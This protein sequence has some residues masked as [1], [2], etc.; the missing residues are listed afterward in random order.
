MIR[1][2]LIGVAVTTVCGCEVADLLRGD[3]GVADP[4][5]TVGGER[6]RGEGGEGG[7]RPRTGVDGGD[8]APPL[9]RRSALGERCVF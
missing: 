6:A 2:G 9:G 5:P 7:E 1:V 3:T 4:N 8:G